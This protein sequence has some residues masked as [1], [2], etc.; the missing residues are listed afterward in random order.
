LEW[1]VLDYAQ[2]DGIP[3]L[4]RRGG[5]SSGA[6]FTLSKTAARGG[7]VRVGSHWRASL[8]EGSDALVV[9]GG[10]STTYAGAWQHGLE[11]AQRALDLV[12]VR[13]FG[14]LSI[15]NPDED[16]LVWW[17]RD[18][19]LTLRLFAM[20]TSQFQMSLQL[21]VRDAAGRIVRAKTPQADWHESY[22]FFRLAQATDDAFDA[23]RN[24]FLA[25]E[26]LLDDLYPKTRSESEPEWLRRALGQVHGKAS[27]ES[28]A[29]T[30][31]KDP[32]ADI[33][34]NIYSTTRTG[35][36]H[37]KTNHPH[38]TPGG[39]SGGQG[40]HEHLERL[41][42]LYLHVAQHE[43]GVRRASS[44][45][46]LYTFD[47]VMDST[48]GDNPV[49]ALSDDPAPFDPDN[50]VLNPAGGSVVDLATRRAPEYDQPFVRN[51]LGSTDVKALAELS[52]IARVGML[53]DGT[54][55]SAQIRDTRLTVGGF[56]VLEVRF[57]HRVENQGP[58]K[59]YPR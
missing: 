23:Y 52:R 9:R 53:H 50:L 44:G 13:G 35:V 58:R 30:R 40:V 32:V 39:R 7:S 11:A 6:V 15:Q 33:V 10:R 45:I 16:H 25:L 4:G 42:R 29:G 47:Q 20:Q 51:W 14:D 49:L 56:D 55:V 57:A 34:R 2:I 43:L 38:F 12:S 41:A 26:C 18:S 3:L 19:R 17:L 31:S 5:R 48:Y 1:L 54:V 37:A 28:L 21:T 46:T 27:L 36:F 22:R 59:I 8:Q 24:L